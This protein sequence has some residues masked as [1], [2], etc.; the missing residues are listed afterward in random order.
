MW[1][2]VNPMLLDQAHV[3][4]DPQVRPRLAG[5]TDAEYL[6]EPVGGAWNVRPRGSGV[7]PVQAGGGDFAIDFAFPEPRPAPVT[8]VAWRLGH[9]IVGVLGARNAAHFGGP[10]CD[11]QSFV[12]AGGAAEALDQLD[13]AYDI[14]TAGSRHSGR[15]AVAAMWPG[16]RPVRRGLLWPRWC[17]TSI[18]R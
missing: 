10:P 13:S 18:V 7:A 4:L 12:Y 15:R 11:Y 16:R 5:L 8:T 9:V 2:A 17:C 14:W 3:A 6:A 1:L